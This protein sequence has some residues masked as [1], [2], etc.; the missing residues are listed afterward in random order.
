MGPGP[1]QVMR[2]TELAKGYVR[3]PDA[4]P[5][6]IYDTVVV[7]LDPERQL[8]N[9][10][11]SS[12]LRWLD[13]LALTER[14]RLPHIGCGVGYYTAIASIAVGPKGRVVGVEVDP[15]LAAQAKRNLGAYPNTSVIC[16]DGLSGLPG[17]CDAIFVNAGCTHPSLVW[18][19]ELAIGGRLLIPLTVSV[20][21][22]NIGAGL[23][24]LITRR[25]DGYEARFTTQVAIF[26]CQGGRTDDDN[27]L[28]ANAFAGR[29]S[30]T[31][32]LLRRDP[33]AITEACWLHSNG[34][35]LS[36]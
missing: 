6:H 3:T 11:P 9:G 17:P 19:D 1:W 21:L 35:C 23:M 12:L 5:S 4:N 25:E 29:N 14:D 8:N 7:A 36:G 18:L 24:L 22:K 33:H 34:Y 30:Q 26:H 15:E 27:Q 2:P 32:R 13:S 16:G 10:E 31:V 28:L 20:P